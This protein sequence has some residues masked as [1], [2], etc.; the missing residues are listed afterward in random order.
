M[1]VPRIFFY[2]QNKIVDMDKAVARVVRSLQEEGVYNNTVLVFMSD[3]G[4]RMMVDAV[5]K[6][7][8]PNFPLKGYKGTIYEGGTKVP[9]FVHSPLIQHRG[10][11]SDIQAWLSCIF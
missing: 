5:G 11:R 3:N 6:D 4:G 1:T 8:N 10:Y 9:A 7:G 2:R